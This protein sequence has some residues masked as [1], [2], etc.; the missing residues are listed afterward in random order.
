M[1]GGRSLVWGRQSYRLS[2]IDFKAASRDGYGDD[3]PISY[4]DL[5]PYYDIVEKYVGISGAAEG[6]EMLPD[7]QFLP[8]MKMSCGEVLLRERVKA[9]IRPHRHHRP[10]GDPHAESQ[11]AAGL[12]LLRSVRARLPH[13]FL[14]QQ[15]VHHRC[16][17]AEL[18]QLH[19]DH[20]RRR[21]PRQHGSRGRTRPAA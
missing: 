5:A 15:P 2:D 4:A 21:Q 10:R 17:R 20:E 8:P 9:K 12:P 1:L 6:N 14:L 7:G 19:A 18:R 13:V 11:R 16:G 3:W